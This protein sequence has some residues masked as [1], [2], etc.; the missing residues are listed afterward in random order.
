MEASTYGLDI[1]RGR[2]SKYY[3][4]DTTLEVELW[5]TPIATICLW[6]VMNFNNNII[7]YYEMKNSLNNN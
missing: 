5:H 3:Y 4:C 7:S 6:L 1:L 2:I